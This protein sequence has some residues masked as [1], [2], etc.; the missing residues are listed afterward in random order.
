MVLRNSFRPFPTRWS[1]LHTR[2]RVG[3]VSITGDMYTILPG[4]NPLLK[5]CKSVETDLCGVFP[6]LTIRNA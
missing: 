2:W 4:I 3:R 5:A 1:G 6:H